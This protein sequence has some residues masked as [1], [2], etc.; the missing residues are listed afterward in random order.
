[1]RD[2]IFKP[3]LEAN[4][5]PDR[6]LLKKELAA[7]LGDRM[8]DGRTKYLFSREPLLPQSFEWF[9]VRVSDGVEAAS[10]REVPLEGCEQDECVTLCAWVAMNNKT[11]RGKEPLNVAGERHLRWIAEHKFS[12]L[13]DIMDIDIGNIGV[14]S[15]VSKGMKLTRAYGHLS[16]HGTVK[17]AAGLSELMKLGV[18]E[19]KAYGFGLVVRQPAN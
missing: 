12:P 5:H 6:T 7:V 1:M 18:G 4:G 11:F 3:R 19:S 13:I 14:M 17:D 10:M 15:A 8:V 16:V 2:F 9:R